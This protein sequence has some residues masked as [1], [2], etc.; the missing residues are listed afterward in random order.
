MSIA[1]ASLPD[2][3]RVV[4]LL[5][6]GL[7]FGVAVAV[8]RRYFTSPPTSKLR[9]FHVIGVAAGTT[10]LVAGSA[11]DVV[12][13]LGKPLVWYGAPIG[14]AG[15]ALIT[16]ALA[17]LY[18]SQPAG[19]RPMGRRS[20]DRIDPAQTFIGEARQTGTAGR[21]IGLIIALV[22]GGPLLVGITVLGGRQDRDRDRIENVR[23][24][25]DEALRQALR[26]RRLDLIRG[27]EEDKVTRSLNAR[28]WRQAEKARRRDRDFDVAAIYDEVADGLETLGDVDCQREFPERIR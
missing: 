25:T 26:E 19:P 4:F 14:F 23:R 9:R 2:S 16:A 28:A 7:Y 3:I 5:T 18:A 1:L 8:M 13:R 17:S 11:G 12:D 10:L 15:V 20:T 21:L 27:C 24:V 6:A 22:V